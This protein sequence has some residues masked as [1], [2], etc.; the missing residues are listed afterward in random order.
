MCKLYEF[1]VKKQFPKELEER[2]DKTV[3]ELVCIMSE[4]LNTLYGENPTEAEYAEF[5]ETLVMAYIGFLEKAVDQLE[6]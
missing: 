6:H 3:Q 2:L 1:P 5:T 4:G